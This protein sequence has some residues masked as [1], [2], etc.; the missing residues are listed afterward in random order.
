MSV[1]IKRAFQAYK[2]K[3]SANNVF[4][5][6]FW[7]LNKILNY[8]K[9]SNLKKPS[10]F[11]HNHKLSHS[12]QDLNQPSA[13]DSSISTNSSFSS[14][15]EHCCN[16]DKFDIEDFTVLCYKALGLNENLL[17]VAMMF[18][19]KILENNF[20][21]SDENIHKTFFLCMMEAQKFYDDENFSN[22]D[23]AKFC[24]IPSEELLELELEFMDY[25]QYDLNISDDKFFGYKKRLQKVFQTNIII[26]NKYIEEED[27]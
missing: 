22:K 5:S 6:I 1:V 16:V 24:G 2:T 12:N 26:P 23:Y 15:D 25:I 8:T 21:I 27:N 9:T 3:F 4:D 11:D 18:L 17:I 13:D 14:D 10:K 7:I 19:D 20:V